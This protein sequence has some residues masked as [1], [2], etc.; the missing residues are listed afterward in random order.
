[1]TTAIAAAKA[2]INTLSNNDFVGVIKFSSSANSL[3]NGQIK[4]ATTQYKEQLVT[5]ID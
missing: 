3:V 1:M 5:A 4:R 2:V